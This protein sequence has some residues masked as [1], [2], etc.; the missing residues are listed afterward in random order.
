MRPL[1][2][3]LL[4]T[5]SLPAYAQE[6]ARLFDLRS[7]EVRFEADRLEADT[8][9]GRIVARGHVRLQRGDA[10]LEADE[11]IID[12][13]AGRAKTRGNVRIR[14]G[15]RVMLS[16]E[17]EVDLTSLVTILRGAELY[18]KE[19][20][21]PEALRALLSERELRRAGQNAMTVLGGRILKGPGPAYYLEDGSI[22]PCDCGD[23]PPSWK[24]TAR[25]MTVDPDNGAW[26]LSPTFR[27]GD[28]GILGLPAIWVPFG[29]HRTGF[30][31][32]QLSYTGINGWL[33]QG[34]F[35]WAPTRSFDSTFVADY[36]QS[37]GFRPGAEIRYAASPASYGRVAGAWVS[38]SVEKIDRF[39]VDGY[40]RQELLPGLRLSLDLALVSDSYYIAHYFYAVRDRSV[41][42]LT[43]TLALEYARGDHAAV[44]AGDYYQD[45]AAATGPRIDLFSSQTGATV[46]RLPRASYHLL[47]RP[48]GDSPVLLSLRAGFNH[49]YRIGSAFEDASGDGAFQTGEPARIFRR[50]DFGASLAAPVEVG[51]V[52]LAPRISFRQLFWDATLPG[53]PVTRGHLVLGADL[54]APF[55]RLFGWSGRGPAPVGS[56]RHVLEP[57]LAYRYVPVTYERGSGAS[58]VLPGLDDLDGLYAAHRLYAGV[59]TRIVQKTAETS[60]AVPLEARLT[61]GF[62]L[63][64]R[65][66]ADTRLKARGEH[67]FVATDLDLSYDPALGQIDEALATFTLRSGRGDSLSVSYNY[68]RSARHERFDLEDVESPLFRGA[69]A[70]ARVG[71]TIHEFLV[72]PSIRLPIP[73]TLSW[74]LQYS[75]TLKDIIQS[76]YALKYESPCR[77]WS[78]SVSVAQV[79]GISMPTVGFFLSL[80]GLG[81]GGGP[82]PVF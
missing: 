12:Q 39:N 59:R 17:L 52:Q 64:T 35:F 9:R 50:F 28:D 30:L 23:D 33:G 32:P 79:L 77:C 53:F 75:F 24:I 26:L 57:I 8:A 1:I 25:K 78:V 76:V 47:P 71:G 48:L 34:S 16:R 73:L 41:E 31:Q 58:S 60:F 38:D 66:L 19:G 63:S 29:D 4:T 6:L 5:L 10:L 45:L 7:G 81:A 82:L 20:V 43:S 65:A 22:T 21:T 80:S 68:L 46:H 54:A 3:L 2:A 55:S 18:V 44:V 67:R 15:N 61:Q 11:L 74:T 72:S 37:R 70:R 69:S 36:V 14:A 49:F 56:W 62:D 13:T 40:L 27:I 42:Y 51:G